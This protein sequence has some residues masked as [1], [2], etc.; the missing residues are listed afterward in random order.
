MGIGKMTEIVEQSGC[1]KCPDAFQGK[2]I[3][4][5]KRE[6]RPDHPLGKKKNAETVAEPCMGCSRVNLI[7]GTKLPDS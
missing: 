1:K 2:E 7:G 3:A 5:L 6:E 4:G